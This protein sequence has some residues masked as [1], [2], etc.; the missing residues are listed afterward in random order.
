MLEKLSQKSQKVIITAESIA[1]DLG[2][3][4]VG[5]E[6]LLIS[7]LRQKNALQ[8][9]CLKNNVCDEDIYN[10]VIRH[11]GKKDIQPFYM[12]YSEV[13]KKILDDAITMSEARKDSKVSLNTVCIALLSQKESVAF[14]LLSDFISEQDLENFCEYLYS[15]VKDTSQQ[16]IKD[17]LKK[18][19]YTKVLE[20][21]DTKVILGRDDEIK[22]ILVGLCCE[23][24]P[25]IALTGYTGVGKT[26]VVE[27]LS[28]YLQ[29][30]N[31][32]EKL[33]D[34]VV[35]QL[36]LTSS[37]AGT[38]YR[39]EFEEKIQKYLDIIKGEKVITFIDEGHQLIGAGGAEGAISAAEILK[40]YLARGDFRFIIATTEEEFKIIQSDAALDRRFRHITINE[41]KIEDVPSMIDAK[42]KE[43]SSYHNVNI[44]DHDVK[45]VVDLSNDIKNRYFPDKALDVIDYT[46][47]YCNLLNEN[48][49][50]IN[51]SIEYINNML[52][53]ETLR[54]EK[55]LLN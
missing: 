53:K 55:Q 40:P 29:Y 49:F 50:N 18:I 24:K 43:Y 6:H 47:S 5:S 28:R 16:K 4:S 14:S 36:D 23:N 41:P 37:V 7:I 42:V 51:I 38:K 27:E 46:M 39:G 20:F 35:I 19:N 8:K 13:V 30:D 3:S 9:F 12:E 22:N 10:E 45:N 17:K 2:H 32:V 11:F 25:N 26:A 54:V 52:G 31:T 1:F 44:T 48:N 15:F 34:Y 21:K 33:K